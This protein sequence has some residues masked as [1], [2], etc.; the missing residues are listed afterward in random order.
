MGDCGIR[1]QLNIRHHG[2]LGWALTL[3]HFVEK[4]P[5]GLPFRAS[6]FQPFPVL[7]RLEVERR[8]I[9]PANHKNQLFEGA[10]SGKIIQRLINEIDV[11]MTPDDY[12]VDF[13]I[14]PFLA[15]AS[16]I[17]AVLANACAT[18]P[19]AD[20]TQ[21][22]EE[23]EAEGEKPAA[24]DEVSQ[25]IP[26]PPCATTDPMPTVEK[27][28]DQAKPPAGG[29]AIHQ[30]PKPRHKKRSTVKGGGREKLIAAL[31]KHHDYANG[32]CLNLELI[33]NNELAR[34]AKVSPSTASEFFKKYF[35][36]WKKYRAI[37]NRGDAKT[38]VA[39]LKLMNDEFRPCH[40]FETELADR[41]DSEDDE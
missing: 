33:G 24:D 39:A 4:W 13:G 2:V 8:N 34:K 30:K 14:D 6:C 22:T 26:P 40:L 16:V 15:S 28:S 18:P 20:A 11:Q 10:P 19:D 41:D 27:W 23:S 7:V 37:C 1:A 3:F 9:P 35:K 12:L 29:E 5:T 38:L 31:T 21:G 25:V 17:D 36:G 32:S